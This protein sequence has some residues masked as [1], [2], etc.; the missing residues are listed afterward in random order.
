MNSVLT[1]VWK[2]PDKR[3]KNKL[4]N[5]CSYL[6]MFPPSLPHYFIDQFTAEGDYVLDPFCGRGTTLLEASLLKRIPIGNDL[7]PLA[8]TL[9]FSKVNVPSYEKVKKRIKQLQ[10]EYK[11]VDISGEPEDIKMLFDEE[12]TLPQLCYLKKSLAKNKPIDMFIFSILLGIMHGQHKKDGSSNCLSIS[13]PNTFSMSPNYIRSYIKKN[14]L[15][16]IKQDVFECLYKR[17]DCIY[18]FDSEFTKGY[19][20]QDDALNLCN[21][22]Y[23]K[24]FHKIKLI[25]TSPPYLKVIN[26]GRYNWIRLWLLDKKSEVVD[27]ELRINSAYR[28][29]ER[30]KLSDD[31][32]LDQYLEF[33]KQLICGWEK[34]TTENGVVAI[35]IGDVDNHKGVDLNLAKAVWD[36]VKP[37]TK[38][39]KL[40]IIKDSIDGNSKVTKIW[41]RERKGNATKTDRILLLSKDIKALDKA[42]HTK[43]VKKYYTDLYGGKD[44]R[45]QI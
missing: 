14:N 7:N 42:N 15:I 45:Q 40:A 29:V 21:E 20:F 30:I 6:A 37:F 9:S 19:I 43:G 34:L 22:K 26:Y 18:P 23:R 38:F 41:G 11:P 32:K 35:V 24:F 31:L 8:Y 10:F 27:D 2:T 12:M 44:V 16:K 3:W 28:K 4:H 1:P 5:V 33:M 25:I 36:F 13:M 17:L 39:K